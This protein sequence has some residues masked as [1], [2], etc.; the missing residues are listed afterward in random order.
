MLDLQKDIN[1]LKLLLNF[2][3]KQ[4]Y[5]VNLVNLSITLMTLN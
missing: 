1:I 4:H 2:Y 5:R 3:G